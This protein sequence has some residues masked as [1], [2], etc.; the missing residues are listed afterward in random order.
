MVKVT[1]IL[2]QN[3]TYSFYCAPNAAILKELRKLLILN[4]ESISNQ[5]K[6]EDLIQFLVDGQ[7]QKA[8]TFLRSALVAIETEPPVL[9][10]SDSLD[11]SLSTTQILKNTT[12]VVQDQIHL[13]IEK[14]RF[15][16]IK[17]FL[18]RELNEQLKNYVI[19]NK[20]LF[21][22]SSVSTRDQDYRR[23]QVL[24]H[25]Q[26]LQDVFEKKLREIYLPKIMP[27]FNLTWQNDYT[28]ES[29]VT[30]SQNG[31]FFKLH[32]DN[33]SPDTAARFF[34]YV[35]YFHREPKAFTGGNLRLFDGK[36]EAGMWQA[37]EN[38]AELEPMNNSIVFFLSRS[39][40][41]VLPVQCVDPDFS[42]SR[43]TINGWVR[44]PHSHSVSFPSTRE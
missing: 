2:K 28:L 41:E 26:P 37:A 6:Q 12:Q 36:I 5:G 7:P 21:T 13:G 20:H 19:E 10:Q 15:L 33:G 8:L 35:Y 24:Y 27:L 43:F 44:Q 22:G 9:L 42:C 40:H 23:S 39:L 14:A 29:Q 3:A 11:P 34:T 30:A 31:D 18:P 38:Y 17:D 25:F 1:L 4:T 16:Q 32:N